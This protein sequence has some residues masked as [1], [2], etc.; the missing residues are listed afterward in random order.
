LGLLLTLSCVLVL[1]DASRS[2]ARCSQWRWRDVSV[3]DDEVFA[4]RA[5]ADT[6]V[7][8]M[9]TLI[10]TLFRREG[11]ALPGLVLV[12][13]EHLDEPSVL[14]HEATHLHQ[15]K[16]DGLLRFASSYVTD[17]GRGIWN[18]CT[19]YASYNAVGYERHATITGNI[20]AYETS[21]QPVPTTFGSRNRGNG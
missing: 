19:L 18:G 7:R 10:H 11:L 12:V 6:P 20:L 9:P 14:A 13:E 3:R 16:R 1:Y 17:Y 8:R 15:M 5:Y 2:S 4:A 21:H